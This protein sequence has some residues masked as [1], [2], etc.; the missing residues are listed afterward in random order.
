M[1]LTHVTERKLG[2]DAHFLVPDGSSLREEVH[3]RDGEDCQQEENIEEILDQ[4]KVSVH[5]EP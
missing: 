3:G 1:Y 5:A 4:I 2:K